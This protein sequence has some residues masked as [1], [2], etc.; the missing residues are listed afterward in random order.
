MG[1][2]KMCLVPWEAILEA[3][4]ALQASRRWLFV[5]PATSTETLS[6][7]T[8]TLKRLT[9]FCLW[10]GRWFIARNTQSFANSRIVADP[11]RL[12]WSQI[13]AKA[14]NDGFH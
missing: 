14:N 13:S 8:G 1:F 4:Q 3:P 11:R 6:T 12:D 7:N 10:N 9:T 5:A 2:W